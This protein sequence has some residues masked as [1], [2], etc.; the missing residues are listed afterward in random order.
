MVWS[1]ATSQQTYLQRAY[2]IQTSPWNVRPEPIWKIYLEKLQ[3]NFPST[4][5]RIRQPHGP[6][7]YPAYLKFFNL[8]A[9][10]WFQVLKRRQALQECRQV[11]VSCRQ[12]GGKRQASNN[13]HC[14][15]PMVP[16]LEIEIS[17][18]DN[19]CGSNS[20]KNVFLLTVYGN[21]S[22]NDEKKYFTWKWVILVYYFLLQ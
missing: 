5:R 9:S 6:F 18:W 3:K 8:S 12:K 7:I 16:G 13:I 20:T 14:L 21:C 4:Q 10:L 17:P 22:K 15:G 19:N 2:C 11:S 1:S